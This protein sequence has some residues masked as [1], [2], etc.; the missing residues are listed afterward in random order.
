M[1]ASTI[2]LLGAEKA[3]FKHIKFGSK[4]PKY[5]VLFKLPEITAA[6]KWQKGRI[7]RAYA[8]KLA[9]ALR[10][11]Y[12]SKNFIAE[13]LKSQLSISLAKIMAS[14]QPEPRQRHSA[15][16]AHGKVWT[17]RLAPKSRRHG[18]AKFE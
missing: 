2:Q 13:D 6:N 15:K 18:H 11:D 17:K 9:I 4:P 10:A 16:Q 1:P 7:A 14:K 3:L 12:F 8:A 5:G